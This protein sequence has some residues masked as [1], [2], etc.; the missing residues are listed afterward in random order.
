MAIMPVEF[1]LR[2]LYPPKCIVCGRLL[3]SNQTDLCTQCR[4]ALADCQAPEMSGE[5]FSVCIPSVFY[6]DLIRESVLRYKFGALPHYADGY[7]RIV[8]MTL[9]RKG[10]T[11]F[12]LVTWVPVSAPRRRRR[13]YDQA[14]LLAQAVARELG[15]P[16]GRTLRKPRD[17]PAQS[18]L[19]GT[20][21]RR[22]NVLGRYVHDGRSVDKLRVLLIDDVVTTGA[23]LS[24]CS[25]VL[26]TAGANEVVCATLARTPRNRGTL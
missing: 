13:G 20:P 3:K 7:G 25:R 26:R 4:M 16:V 24:E 15:L 11:A 5:F 12:D 19:H 10:Q 21:A 18:S 17:N 8:A 2:L 1:L 14:Q 22:A 9:R 6:Q 23:T